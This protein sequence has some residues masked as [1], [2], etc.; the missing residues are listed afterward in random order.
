MTKIL[1]ISFHLGCHNDLVYIGKELDLD[2]KFLEFTDG[3][4][5]KYNIGHDRAEK[6]WNKH[7]DYFNKFDVIITSDT[8]PIARV[9]L[10]S[11]WSKKLIIWI[12][13][14]FDYHDAASLDCD[15]PDKEYYELFKKATTMP[16]VTIAGYTAFE[17]H[18][19][20]EWRQINIGDLIINLSFN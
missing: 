12:N 14:R 6:Y 20:N 19:C 10:Q 8:A 3:T 7:K 16:N 18:Y 1:H 4:P 5:G 11:N 2:I 13:N 15:F 9:F 17:N